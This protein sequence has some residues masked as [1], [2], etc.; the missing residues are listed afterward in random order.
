MCGF[1][2]ASLAITAVGAAYSAYGQVQ[3]GKAQQAQYNYQAAVDRNNKKITDW[4]AKDAIDRGKEEERRRRLQTQQT[5]GT[6]R[7]SFAANGI[8]LGSENVSDTLADTAMTGELDALT[9][10]S[11]AARDAWGYKVQGMNYMASAGN[12]QLAGRNARQAGRTGAMSTILGGAST[13]SQNAYT[14]NKNG[15]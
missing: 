11:N 2:A 4:Q 12:N 5:M 3:A 13:V 15:W 10:R 8:D 14:Y 7:V 9:I 1:A 6:Q